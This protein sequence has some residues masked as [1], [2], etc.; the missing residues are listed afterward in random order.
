MSNLPLISSGA[1]KGLKLLTLILKIMK[2]SRKRNNEIC[3]KNIP[4]LHQA[5]MR[6]ERLFF[7]LEHTFNGHIT[8][9]KPKLED[10][11]YI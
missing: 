5:V 8:K 11:S 3:H 1:S 7:D 9:N 6:I 10:D 4:E 2:L